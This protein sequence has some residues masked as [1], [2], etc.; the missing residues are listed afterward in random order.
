MTPEKAKET[1][2]QLAIEIEKH[3]YLYYTL[4]KPIISDQTFDALLRQLQAL[5]RQYPNFADINS[6][7][8]RV[9]GTITRK[10]ETFTHIRPMLS[11]PNTYTREE[12]L[13]FTQKAAQETNTYF[14][15][16]HKF[17]GV[18]LSLHY[19]K[20]ILTAAVTRGDGQTGDL[21]T[22]NART[23]RNIPLSLQ[24][25]NYPENVEVRGEVFMQKK[26]FQALNEE[27]KEA[28][29]A[30]LMNP[31]NTT[32][33]T[34]KLQD[35]AQVAKRK[36]SFVAYYAESSSS[37]PRSDYERMQ[38]LA[39]W[40]FS[41]DK[42]T[43]KTKSIIEVEN[44]LNY[45]K[46][47]IDSLPYEIDGIVIKVD[48]HNTR[49]ELGFTAKIPRWAIAYKYATE[50][51]VT[52]LLSVSF[53]VGRTGII[54]PIANLEPVLL[55][56]TIV[57]RASLYNADELERL[58]LS[59]GDQVMVEKG[60]EIIPKVVGIAVKNTSEKL[61]EFI[62]NCPACGSILSNNAE[63][64]GVYCTNYQHC[65]PQIAGKIEHFAARKAMAIDGLGTEIIEQLVQKELVTTIADLY[66]ITFEQLVQLDRLGKKSA[67]N[68][69]Q[70]IEGSKSIPFHRVL[71]ALGIRHVG[72]TIAEKLAQHFHSLQSLSTATLQE[73]L[74][75][76][77]IGPTIAQSIVDYFKNTDNQ[78]TINRLEKNGLQLA[79]THKPEAQQSSQKLS[80]ISILISGTFE[81]ISRDELK[82][83][84]T[85]NGGINA[86]GV[87]KKLNY[88]L[89]GNEAGSSKVSKAE[90]LNIPIISLVE[91]QKLLA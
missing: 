4:A 55:G 58:Q 74:S 52:S 16:Q 8:Q 54:T 24:G 60:G 71:F 89:A 86:S 61:I 88:L 28:G 19:Q 17:D 5:E 78:L 80:G 36:L 1:M 32:A 69:I 82:L 77:E 56:G 14:I 68:L 84:I 44:Y 53:Q 29:E 21:I 34:L 35:S 83:I 72:G 27:R 26:D 46:S 12:L 90:E 18:A 67:Q 38:L 47:N 62:K 40:G 63:E 76:P 2:Q 33:G 9:G 39:Q 6:P 91:F 48:D 13:N 79:Y 42:N 51:A 66:D 37:L 85:Q 25:E 64:V 11:L 15:I 59:A 7:T 81:N 87:S 23:I 65:K 41:I 31:R 22:A 70:A 30:L 20:G 10:F 50:Q 75:V 45:W 3:N 73:L 49:S 43:L 57:K